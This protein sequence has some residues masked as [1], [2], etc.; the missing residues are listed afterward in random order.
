MLLDIDNLN[1][2]NINDILKEIRELKNCNKNV[3]ITLLNILIKLCQDLK[4]CHSEILY[5]ICLTICEEI[6]E[7]TP[8]FQEKYLRIMYYVIHYLDEKVST[9]F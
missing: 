2:N 4:K 1:K 5:Q 6:T 3:T 9:Y 7:L 8:K